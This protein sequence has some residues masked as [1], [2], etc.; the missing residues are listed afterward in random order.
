MFK[1]A[2]KRNGLQEGSDALIVYIDKHVELKGDITY[3]GSGRIDGKLDGRI[4]VQGS[5]VLGEDAVVI[6][7]IEADIVV[8]AGKVEGNI[9][10]R[11]KVQLLATAKF[12]GDISTPLL[13]I[14]EGAWFNGTTRM[15]A[16]PEG[17]LSDT[18]PA[19]R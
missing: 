8:I 13:L 10:A 17:S 2:V 15:P 6:S 18:K 3:N 5:V 11:Q 1:R 16:T 12:C 9:S 4:T 7:E 14:E 19:T